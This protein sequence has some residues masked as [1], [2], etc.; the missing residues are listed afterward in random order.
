MRSF[1][2]SKPCQVPNILHDS[3]S[4]QGRNF[5]L[6]I[7]IISPE[8]QMGGG[9]AR[10]MAYTH[11]LRSKNHRVSIIRFPG[12]DVS[13]KVWYYYQRGFARLQGND[14][15]YMVKAADRFERI[16]K[17]GH[18]DAVIAVE[19]PSSY[20]LTRELGCLK[21]FSCESLAAD[22]LYFSKGYSD[23]ESIKKLRA[24]ELEIIQD[25]DYVVFPW[26]TTEN[27]ARKYLYNGDNLVTIK[28]GCYPQNKRA[29]YFFPAS[30]I[31]LGDLRQYWSNPELVD[32]LT[33]ISP[34]HIESYSRK[35]NKNY[36]IIYRGFAPSQDV[37]FNYQF[38]LNSVSKDLFRRNHFSS[39]II[40][41]LSYGLPVLSPDWMQLSHELKGVLPFN[42]NNFLEIVD[43]YASERAEWERISKEAY[44]QS[45][46]LDWKIVLQPLG[47][48]IE[49]K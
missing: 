14:L 46:E 2:D 48:L 16:I 18:F 4:I 15:R 34:Y 10:T 23:L 35:P 19:T 26:K 29:S 13:S 43:K 7:L 39:R 27:Y 40:N 28:Y 45:L 49:D 21:I 25:S 20:V 33:K 1:I 8:S 6:N 32:Y 17:N 47:E 31:S 42:E 12:D 11:F 36:K 22:E 30:I 3:H 44:E 5:F 41:Y 9:Q 37:L 24:L 38:G